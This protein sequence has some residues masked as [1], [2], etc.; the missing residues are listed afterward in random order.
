MASLESVKDYIQGL[1]HKE[2]LRILCVYVVAFMLLVGFFLYR[3]FD[4]LAEVEQKTKLLN[5]ARQD[6]QIILTEYD[7]IKNKK[8]EVDQLLTE[9]KNF[10]LLKFYQDTITELKIESQASPSLV[11][12]AGPTG[13]TEESLQVNLTQITMK[14][15]CEFLQALQA[16][17]RISVKNLDIVKSNVEKKINANMSIATLKP[18]IEKT[19]STK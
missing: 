18:V 6:V 13:Y 11:S 2:V 3:H 12:G 8:K 5:K 10:Y 16:K 7:H 4:G 19:S 15:L 9:D 17:P 14:Q 1:N